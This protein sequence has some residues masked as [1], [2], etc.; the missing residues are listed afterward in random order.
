M[1]PSPSTFL[2]HLDPEI[3][4]FDLNES[5]QNSSDNSIY[6]LDSSGSE[7]D[8][9]VIEAIDI[10]TYV[11]QNRSIDIDNYMGRPNDTYKARL[12]QN[13]KSNTYTHENSKKKVGET[14][15]NSLG[16]KKSMS[17]FGIQKRVQTMMSINN[18][19]LDIDKYQKQVNKTKKK[20][21]ITNEN[22]V[23]QQIQE[24]HKNPVFDLMTIPEDFRDDDNDDD[25]TPSDDQE[26]LREIREFY[27][28]VDEINQEM[29]QDQNKYSDDGDID[30]VDQVL[31]NYEAFKT[32]FKDQHQTQ[33]H[34][35]IQRHPKNVVKKNI[36][37]TYDIIQDDI[38]E[39]NKQKNILN[40]ISKM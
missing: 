27:N 19:S 7:S 29:I 26:P 14:D 28:Q 18:I 33:S 5:I 15:Y 17:N 37:M 23:K 8:E 1:K 4:D 6:Q 3:P 11:Q 12:H 21:L 32:N 34:F 20:S 36:D 22:D 31:I 24:F 25:R 16:T 9:Q 10:D 30:F 39:N 2:I 38:P 40:N 13:F 35:T